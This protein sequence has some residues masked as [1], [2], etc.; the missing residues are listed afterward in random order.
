MELK[1]CG[2]LIAEQRKQMQWTQ[3]QLGEKVGVSDKAVSKWERGLSFPDVAIVEKLAE[4]LQ[5]SIAELL[6]GER[7]LHRQEK[8]EV[9]LSDTL[10]LSEV[11]M[12]QN[13]RRHRMRIALAVFACLLPFFVLWCYIVQPV[14][15]TSKSDT[16][17][18]Q[19]FPSENV[20]SL[21]IRTRVNYGDFY[22]FGDMYFR[23]DD[24]RYE[25]EEKIRTWLPDCKVT[26][27]GNSILV[28][29]TDA[30][31]KTD[32]YLFA[33]RGLANGKKAYIWSGMRCTLSRTRDEYRD[34]LVPLHLFDDARIALRHS[35][36][37]ISGT[38]YE[39]RER[40]GIYE[41]VPSQKQDV[42]LRT[43]RSF[44][45][46]CGWFDVT[47]QDGI[48]YVR[49]EDEQGDAYT[50]TVELVWHCEQ[51]YCRFELL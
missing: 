1:K 12:R 39:V 27:Y 49:Q 36:Q 11:Q 43:F 6:S 26:D 23:S 24:T 31:G 50:F 3:K 33:L 22:A 18:A 21:P 10:H 42:T 47:E 48:L 5:L 19:A 13:R 35:V 20:L 30:D 46:S 29:Q 41:T 17:S 7:E 44:Y 38:E 34:I 37:L 51:L 45:E 25:L 32:H 9:L 28:S 8:T 16:V 40:I 2:Q 4:V 15:G 14:D